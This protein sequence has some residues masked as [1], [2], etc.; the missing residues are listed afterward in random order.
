MHCGGDVGLGFSV[1]A[2]AHEGCSLRNWTGTYVVKCTGFVVNPDPNAPSGALVPFAEL[3]R[4]VN[5]ADGSCSGS[6]TVSINGLIFAHTYSCVLPVTIR[7]NCTGTDTIDQ[8][9]DGQYAGRSTFN[10]VINPSTGT[11]EEIET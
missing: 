4:N 11:I 3:S 5:Q 8:W 7:S 6:G 1:S 10:A 9:L 2:Q